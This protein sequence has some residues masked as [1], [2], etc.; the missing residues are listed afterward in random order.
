MAQAA[1]DADYADL[2]AAISELRAS[3]RSLRAIA[4]RLNDEGQT[5]RRLKPWNPVQVARVLARAG[6]RPPRPR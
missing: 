2:M 5:T 3:G 6:R 1:A 4:S